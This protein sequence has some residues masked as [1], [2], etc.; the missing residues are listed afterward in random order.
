MTFP[1]GGM[2]WWR[3]SRKFSGDPDLE[4][5][6][7]L[8]SGAPMGIRAPVRH[9]GGIFPQQ[10]TPATKSPEEVL[11]GPPVA[12]HPSFRDLAGQTRP[13]GHQL[14]QEHVGAGFGMIFSTRA[15][16]AKHL[17]SDIVTALL[18]TIAKK[19]DDGSMKYRVVMDLRAN[20]VNSTV[21]C[22]RDRCFRPP[23]ATRETSRL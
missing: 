23:L 1:H 7:W 22:H 13:P 6:S 21:S 17:G 20:G 5:V 4:L 11:A 19:R 14:I 15:A 18:G 3:R 10:S 2:L 8:R 9:R 16:A 12:N